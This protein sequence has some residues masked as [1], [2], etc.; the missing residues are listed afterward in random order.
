[1]WLLKEEHTMSKIRW[2]IVEKVYGK[3]KM[4]FCSLCVAKKVHL[5]EQ[6]NDNRLLN[7]KNK[8]ISGCRHQVKGELHLS[9]KIF[10]IFDY[11]F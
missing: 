8:F 9:L 5:M 4:N 2:S 6:F 1:M 7:K 3:T 11:T 10:I